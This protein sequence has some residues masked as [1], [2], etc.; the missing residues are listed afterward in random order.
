MKQVAVYTLPE[1]PEV[2]ILELRG[3]IGLELIPQVSAEIAKFYDA[4]AVHWAV[5]LS[6]VE[7]L[8]SPAVGVIMGLRSRV[9]QK[10]G[11]V[12]LFA[13]HPDLKEKL[14]LMGVDLAIPAFLNLR[15]FLSYF[16]WEFKGA[17]R[18][19]NATFPATAAVV[20]PMRRLIAGL[21]QSK[22]YTGKETFV[23]ESIVD[24]LANN[25]IE[26]GKPAD[27]VFL[28]QLKFD[29]KKMELSISNQCAELSSEEQ[30]TLIGKYENPQVDPKSIRGRGIA[31]VKKLSSRMSYQVEPTRVEVHVVR[32]REGK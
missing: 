32:L 20:P 21:L 3:D 4:G 31:L 11:S 19:L 15:H 30:K 8:S 23:M 5:D 10:Q 7:F 14:N 18:F 17:S 24:E 22:G 9:L 12:S 25:A 1:E 26:H 29:K 6:D 27:G 16:R 28:L 13:A 2:T